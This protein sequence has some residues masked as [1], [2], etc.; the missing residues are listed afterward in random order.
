MNTE[1]LL[2]H[3]Q[4]KTPGEIVSEAIIAVEELSVLLDEENTKLKAKEIGFLEEALKNKKRA[5]AKMELAMN[6]VKFAKEKVDAD[7][8][9]KANL[10]RLR[11]SLARYKETARVHLRLLRSAHDTT[12][13]FLQMVAQAV[14]AKKPKLQ[15]YGKNGAIDSQSGKATLKGKSI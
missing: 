9:A 3:A 13:D 12:G 5:A 10:P 14:E 4:A 6:L 8:T 1:Q 15:T 11:D 2:K 7:E